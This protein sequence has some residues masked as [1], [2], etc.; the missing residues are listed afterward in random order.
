MKATKQ[1][2]GIEQIKYTQDE[3]T[4]FYAGLIAM[5]EA[6]IEKAIASVESK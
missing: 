5:T 2:A 1:L 3:D 6:A 4:R